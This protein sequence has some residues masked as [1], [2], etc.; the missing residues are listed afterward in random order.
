VSAGLRPSREELAREIHQLAQEHRGETPGGTEDRPLPHLDTDRGTLRYVDA[1]LEIADRLPP[2]ATVLEVGCGA[3][4]AAY[5]LSRLGL[6]VLAADIYPDTPPYLLSL[7]ERFGTTVPYTHLQGDDWRSFVGRQVEAVCLYGVLEHVPDFGGFL[8]S[9]RTVL[10]PDGLLFL[11]AFPN[12][13]SWIEAVGERRP[14]M[15]SFH[16]LRFSPR[17]LGLLLR[18]SGFK[19]ES[20]HYEEILPVNLVNVPSFL[21]G[22]LARSGKAMEALSRGL[23]AVPGVRRLSTNFAMVARHAVNWE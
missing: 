10:Q 16:P 13:T 2:G 18:W 17:E 6:D 14:G 5:L 19:V 23:R 11:F 7:A 15:E 20:W 8:K 9:T 1:A 22:P 12:K 3:G 21:R 4:Q